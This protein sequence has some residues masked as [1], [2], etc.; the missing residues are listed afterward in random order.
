MDFTAR[1]QRSPS[2][3]MYGRLLTAVLITAALSGAAGAQ[4]PSDDDSDEVPSR[5]AIEIILFGYDESV[6]AG[7]E[8]FL[9]DPPPEP[10]FPEFGDDALSEPVFGDAATEPEGTV[11]ANSSVVVNDASADSHDDSAD[12]S[13]DDSLEELVDGEALQVP[14]IEF[15]PLP[16][17]A[18]A[19]GDIHER[20]MRLDAYEPVL[21][22]GW[23][24]YVL[25]VADT[26]AISLHRLGE[27]PADFDGELTL[28]VG[29]FVHLIV[30]VERTTSLP[31][32]GRPARQSFGRLFGG[33]G[34]D[35]D[36]AAVIHYRIQEDR[37]LRNGDLRYFDH[38]KLG[39]IARL[40]LIEEADEQP[41][42][43]DDSDALLPPGSDPS[44]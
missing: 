16:P 30:D 20:L 44:D 22:S 15:L 12:S 33:G 27:L 38:P 8:V 26:P 14:D 3:S 28:Y 5:Y 24:Q 21:W 19:M 18:F 4:S 23:S 11:D 39:L 40:A 35:D 37:I 2:K 29:R 6:S 7:T 1:G 13:Q 17:E 34:G 31:S 25:D 43:G 41:D 42:V 32:A 10:T 36:Q 9:P